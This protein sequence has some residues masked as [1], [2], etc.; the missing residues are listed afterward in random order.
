MGRIKVSDFG[1]RFFALA[2]APKPYA[3]LA[4]WRKLDVTKVTN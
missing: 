3:F 4:A 1:G 2:V